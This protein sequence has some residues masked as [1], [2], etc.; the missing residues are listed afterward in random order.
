MQIIIEGPDG[1]GKTTLLLELAKL[2][3]WR[4]VSGEGPEKWPGEM[5]DRIERYLKEA[6]YAENHNC[7][8]RIFDRHPCISHQIYSMFTNV[9]K[10]SEGATDHLYNL[11]NVIVYCQSPNK[12][13]SPEGQTKAHDR[14]EHL[15]AISDNHLEICNLYD[16]WGVKRAHIIHRFWEPGST[17]RVLRSILASSGEFH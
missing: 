4:I 12:F 14:G 1:S 8:P 10:V 2:T 7:I 9:S 13:L 6:R 3:G 16:S 11:N 5:I 15:K 17:H